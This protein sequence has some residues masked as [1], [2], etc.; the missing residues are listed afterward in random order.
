MKPVRILLTG[1]TV[2]KTHDPQLETITFNRDGSTQIPEI[3]AQGRCYFPIVQKLMFID[4]LDMT[5]EY[6][7]EIA[8]AITAADEDAIVISH[9]TSTMGETAR[10]L[11]EIGFE[12]TIVLTGAMRPWSL[13]HSDADFNFGGAI[14]AAQ[15]LPY[16][17]YGVMNGRVFA[18]D[19]LN[20]NTEQGRFDI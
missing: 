5:D 7:A 8:S 2:E 4:S 11:Q 18:A 20:K 6:R 1:G 13:S 17:A 14:I 3:L 10:Y 12:K 15:I 19:A 9:G 16:G